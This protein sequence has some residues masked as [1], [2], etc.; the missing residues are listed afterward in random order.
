[1]GAVPDPEGSRD[2]IATEF[3]LLIAAGAG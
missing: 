3:A 2:A 1:V